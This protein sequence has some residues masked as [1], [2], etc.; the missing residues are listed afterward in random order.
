[1]VTR[2]LVWVEVQLIWTVSPG[3]KAEPQVGEVTVMSGYAAA[4]EAANRMAAGAA[5]RRS[6]TKA[7]E[8]RP[9][10]MPAHLYRDPSDKDFARAEGQAS[11]F[12][13]GFRAQD[14]IHAGGL[15]ERAGHI[16]CDHALAGADLD[17]LSADLAGVGPED[18]NDDLAHARRLDDGLAVGA[19]DAHPRENVLD[20]DAGDVLLE[21]RVG[22]RAVVTVE[23]EGEAP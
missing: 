16:A 13:I 8:S 22:H 21:A 12:S 10:T 14:H 23:Q 4:G 6:A 7:G 19:L 2:P 20:G 9:P 11:R 1:M 15:H 3:L 18:V 17:G 5:R